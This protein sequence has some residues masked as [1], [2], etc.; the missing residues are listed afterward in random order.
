LSF[1]CAINHQQTNT[2]GDVAFNATSNGEHAISTTTSS[3]DS[4]DAGSSEKE[5]DREK[6]YVR[7]RVSGF[8]RCSFFSQTVG[9]SFVG[10][11]T[12]AN[13][14][15]N[16]RVDR[17]SPIRKP[18]KRGGTGNAFRVLLNLRSSLKVADIEFVD[19][20]DDIELVV[21][22][23]FAIE[24]TQNDDGQ[25]VSVGKPGRQRIYTGKRD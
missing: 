24:A 18:C 17:R 8:G 25:L 4:L 20:D 14:L 2:A 16:C 23:R 6:R 9:F 7:V 12:T 11:K 15:T 5:K 3:K 13:E 22:V 1:V 19:N 21:V 10:R